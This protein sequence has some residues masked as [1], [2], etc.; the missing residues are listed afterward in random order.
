MD[1]GRQLDTAVQNRDRLQDKDFDMKFIQGQMP[2]LQEVERL[3]QQQ[4]KAQERID[5]S[6][7]KLKKVQDN[8]EKNESIL[9]DPFTK[10]NKYKR[11]ENEISKLQAEQQR[12][13]AARDAAKSEGN[14][15]TIKINELRDL[16]R[17]SGVNFEPS[18]QKGTDVTSRTG[19]YQKA[20]E[21]QN[22][23]AKE[24][25]DKLADA[26]EEAGKLGDIMGAYERNIV[27]QE[28]SIRTQDRQY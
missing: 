13:L 22:T 3:F 9:K 23:K 11:A 2:S 16:F 12:I 28:R 8:I 5:A 26:R 17:Q 4:F 19:E 25:A 7:R 21:D 1:Y 6:N 24:L 14:A 15:A 10:I 20:L 27:D 18:Y